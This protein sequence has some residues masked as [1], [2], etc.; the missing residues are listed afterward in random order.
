MNLLQGKI[1]M[2]SVT[3]AWVRFCIGMA[4]LLLAATPIVYVVRWW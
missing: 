3:S 2:E 4:I 1:E